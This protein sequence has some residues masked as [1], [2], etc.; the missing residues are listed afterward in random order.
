MVLRNLMACQLEMSTLL[1]P[2]QRS[3]VTFLSDIMLTKSKLSIDPDLLV[4]IPL[5]CDCYLG[6]QVCNICTYIVCF[7]MFFAL[8]PE[9][10]DCGRIGLSQRSE[11]DLDGLS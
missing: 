7:I 10:L 3:H 9:L 2:S 11:H 6:I 4:E 5:V 1:D 8:L